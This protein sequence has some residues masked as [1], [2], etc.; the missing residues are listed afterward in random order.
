MCKCCLLGNII[1]LMQCHTLGCNFSVRCRKIRLT[2]GC[3]WYWTGPE[4][5]WNIGLPTEADLLPSL[6]SHATAKLPNVDFSPIPW[7]TIGTNSKYLQ[8][9]IMESSHIL[10]NGILETKF[11]ASFADQDQQALPIQNVQMRFFRSLFFLLLI[12]VT[13]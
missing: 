6:F 12:H 11:R 5:H 1:E 2:L 8:L 13:G 4:E 10:L 7:R 3:H 9:I